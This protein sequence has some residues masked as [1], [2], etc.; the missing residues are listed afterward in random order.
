MLNV[1]VE[2]H[3]FYQIN[4]MFHPAEDESGENTCRPAVMSLPLITDEDRALSNQVTLNLHPENLV[5][6]LPVLLAPL[7]LKYSAGPIS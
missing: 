2:S 6:P 3:L 7:V 1:L 4:R 5:F